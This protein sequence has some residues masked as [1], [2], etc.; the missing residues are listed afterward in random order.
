[1]AQLT[2]TRQATT[3]NP[4]YQSYQMQVTISAAENI[5]DKIFVNKRIKNYFD[6]SFQDVVVAIATPVQLED[7]PEDKPEGELGFFRTNNV[8][9]VGRTPDFLNYWWTEA[10]AEIQALV[11]DVNRIATDLS[12]AV[13]TVVTS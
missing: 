4:D 10:S 2:V 5:T 1:M 3:Y 13:V 11:T 9:V 12:S 8:L 7:F 6:D